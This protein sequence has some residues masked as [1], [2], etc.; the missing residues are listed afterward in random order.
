MAALIRA[1]PPIGQ[2]IR[3]LCRLLGLHPPP[4]LLPPRRRRPRA[5]A[6]AEA[7]AEA[8]AEA[9]PRQPAKSPRPDQARPDQPRRRPQRL[10]TMAQYGPPSRPG[11]ERPVRMYMTMPKPGNSNPT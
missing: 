5:V 1:V 2:H 10:R 11:Y 8:T 6:N 3:P 7:T 9:A 4:G